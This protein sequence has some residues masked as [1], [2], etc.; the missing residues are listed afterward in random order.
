M[1]IAKL[2]SQTAAARTSKEEIEDAKFNDN[3]L[4]SYIDN[5]IERA[6]KNGEYEISLNYYYTKERVLGE[7]YGGP[8][9]E[10][11]I[12]HYSREGFFAR[13]ESWL[14]PNGYGNTSLIISWK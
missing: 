9:I 12:R 6:S 7:R 4:R 8:S 13:K 5:L 10:A 14:S 2:R 11:V 3:P 1:D